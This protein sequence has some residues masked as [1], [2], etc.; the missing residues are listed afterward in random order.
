[1]KIIITEEQ[2]GLILE[3]IEPSEAYS[4]EG[5]LR[6][7]MDGKR[8]IALVNDKPSEEFIKSIINDDDDI[9]WV[10]VTPPGSK[11][12]KQYVKRLS[13]SM[14]GVKG[15]NDWA[16]K[17]Y[18]YY[19]NNRD[20]IYRAKKLLSYMESHE[21]FISDSTDREA[22]I[23]GTILG[24]NKESIRNYIEKNYRK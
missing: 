13:K 10:L 18:I 20:G 5:A 16:D 22:A 6:T 11:A 17:N 8:N 2:L 21:G 1:M 9:R 24:Y 4:S 3:T 23:I 15:A 7:L 19:R 12:R 14:W